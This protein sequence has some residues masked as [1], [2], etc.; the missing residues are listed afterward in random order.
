MNTRKAAADDF[1]AIAALISRHNEMPRTQCIH[2]GE[3]AEEILAEIYAAHAQSE[4]AFFLAER[5]GEIA[6][7]FGGEYDEE[8][9]RVWLWGPFAED[10]EWEE[11]VRALE[12]AFFAAL[13]ATICR[14]DSFLHR[15]NERGYAFYLQRGF[16][17]GKISHVYAVERPIV[18]PR[19][20]V[21]CRSA[22]GADADGLIA[23]HEELFPNTYETGW[24]MLEKND[25]KHQLLVVG[26]QGDVQGYVYASL[27]EGGAEGY[28]DFLGVCAE[29]RRRGLG[30]AL[31]ESTL[32]WC[33]V[34]REVLAVHLIVED[35]RGGAR[36][37][38]ER[39]GF[40]LKYT[41]LSARK[42]W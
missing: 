4:I 10:F 13:P 6:G 3:G 32:Q 8:L 41:G 11:V 36:T 28:V 23:L 5:A 2:S 9:G 25:E 31:L 12:V 42:D 24:G 33:F 15:D 29:A 22:V 40:T 7:V 34:Q 20:D 30:R 17:A 14:A 16:K 21:R 19:R 1:P 27:P 35:A 26:E 38:Y 37:L 18:L 39:A